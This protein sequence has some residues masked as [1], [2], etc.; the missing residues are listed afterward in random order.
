MLTPKK[1]IMKQNLL[2]NN[3]GNNFFHSKKFL[4]IIFSFYLLITGFLAINHSPWRDE[5]QS[6]LI[7]RDLNVVGI[8]KQAP[9]EGTPPLWH[10]ILH[11]F[12]AA[13]APYE[14]Q[15][16]FTYL[17]MAT[18]VFL[19]IF[20][21]PLPWWAKILTPF[22]FYFIFQY[23]VVT[24]HYGLMT[25]A[26]FI[27]AFLYQQ[28][29]VRPLLYATTI[30]LLTWSGIQ[31]AAIGS[32]LTLL[33]TLEVIKTYSWKKVPLK[34]YFSIAIMATASL[35][36]FFILQ[37]KTVQA[38][39]G[40]NFYGWNK[41][42]GAFVKGFFP[43]VNHLSLLLRFYLILAFLSLAA[44]YFILKNWTS[45]LV[46]GGALAWLFF[47]FTCKHPGFPYHFGL[48]IIF[49]LFAWW[50]GEI[51]KKI[52]NKKYISLANIFIFIILSTQ[53]A[54]S[55]YFLA[56]NY[57]YNFSSSKTTA[58]YIKQNNLETKPWA[59]TAGHYASSILPYFPEKKM[60]LADTQTMATFMNWDKNW[61]NAGDWSYEDKK[62][63]I[64]NFYQKQTP[65]PSS[66]LI[67]SDAKIKDPDLRLVKSHDE[68]T[69][70]DENIFL[71][72]LTIPL[73]KI[74]Q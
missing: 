17:C 68:I 24:R 74:G 21:S 67:I 13:G 15:A 59:T 48:F 27:V 9:L 43:F 42:L 26:L 31:T 6:W 22:S 73:T 23:S 62:N 4:W 3:M 56:I 52:I 5:A 39:G 1:I 38:W 20:K 12:A 45:R 29:F 32:L 28:R 71:Y 8:I 70:A 19:L 10:L 49:F 25:L 16:V 50:L 2:K 46:F 60:F 40:I 41:A 47:I 44:I 34:Y 37:E 53:V 18:A 55:F 33:F 11:P 14:T 36:V 7:A 69:I 51:N 58:D 65:L 66:V 57:K 63:N 35:A 61:L 30:F 54:Y 64:I 72:E